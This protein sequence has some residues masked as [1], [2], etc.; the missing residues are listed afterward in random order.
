M[1]LPPPS[2]SAAALAGIRVI[3]LAD[4]LAAYASRLLVDLGA[5][6]I[7]VEPPGGS[8]VRRIAPIVAEPDMPMLST[9]DRFVNA[10]KRSVTIDTDEPE[11]IAILEQLLATADIVIESSSP[12]LAPL[13]ISSERLRELNPRIGQVI[14]TP[15][16]L[17]HPEPWSPA[18]DLIV[19]GA[20]GLLHLG[21][22]PDV[23]P[24]AA[25]GA[26]S[27]FAA[28]IFA[29]VAAMTALLQRDLTGVAG[30]YDVSAQECVAQA[31]ED[32]AATYA[33]TGRVRERQGD[34]PREAGSGVYSCKDGYVSMI[35]GRLGTAKAWTALVEW[36]NDAA[37]PEADALLGERWNEF[38]FRQSPEAIQDFA[39]IFEAFARTRTKAELYLEAQARRIALSP[40]STV[41]DVLGNEQLAFR[42][43][44][45]T[46]R[47]TEFDRDLIYPR[48]PY[49]LSGTPTADPRSAPRVGE[50]NVAVLV[51]ELGVESEAYRSLVERGVV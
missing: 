25:Y 39:R 50:D 24:V 14:V 48:A 35:A 30:T 7:R 22:Y 8:S 20:G 29:A 15:F 42:E 21:G 23:G 10:G 16:G 1:T 11:G 31:L 34:R 26:Q 18:N 44:F 27:R 28:S 36:L 3:D 41:E 33:L 46:V 45:V 47:D 13:G 5:E 19:M 37:S 2:G 38:E 51:E 32:S 49:S 4:E 6:V 43:F 17:D 9:F 40:V 12:V